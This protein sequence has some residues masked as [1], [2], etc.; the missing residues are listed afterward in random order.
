L[1]ID[2]IKKNADKWVL[3]EY[4]GSPCIRQSLTLIADTG[5]EAKLYY[6]DGLE[7][8]EKTLGTGLFET[9]YNHRA[10]DTGY[11]YDFTDQSFHETFSFISR[12]GT[13]KVDRLTIIG[14][15]KSRVS[16]LDGTFT[17]YYG[18]TGPGYKPIS[19][20]LEKIDLLL[21]VLPEKKSP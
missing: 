3:L 9:V 5:G 16:Q 6:Y 1:D 17:Y 21:K 19:D 7:V 2:A 4:V 10:F 8:V 13:S 14:G 11:S 12:N 18:G 20:L 15:G